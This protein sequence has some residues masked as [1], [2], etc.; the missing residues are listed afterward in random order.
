MR[1]SAILLAAGGSTRFGQS[2]PLLVFDREPLVRR[3]A[4]AAISVCDFVV[5]V[6]GHDNKK[7]AAALAGLGLMILPHENW[8]RGIGSSLRRGLDFVDGYDG[9][10]VLTCD[11]PFVETTVLREL[12][13]AHQKTAQPIVASSY[14]DTI[15]VPAFFATP[16]ISKLRV[17][18]D[19]SGAKSIITANLNQVAVIPFPLGAIDIDCPTDY[20]HAQMLARENL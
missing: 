2:K 6:T 5:V 14:D 11:Q 9:V 1:I 17:L 8:R 3:V 15:G 4:R 10:V 12:I 7:V 18:P 16:F 19:A 20:E 13:H